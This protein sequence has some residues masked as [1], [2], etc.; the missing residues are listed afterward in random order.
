MHLL[1][2]VHGAEPYKAKLQDPSGQVICGPAFPMFQHQVPRDD[3]P[4]PAAGIFQLKTLHSSKKKIY[5]YPPTRLFLLYCATWSLWG[6]HFLV[7]QQN[8]RG[9]ICWCG[10]A[11]CSAPDLQPE[12]WCLNYEIQIQN[13]W[14][15]LWTR[16]S[17]VTLLNLSSPTVK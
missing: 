4:I 12:K 1:A 9:W 14:S 6:T 5:P 15:L 2:L 10:L 11:P 7:S 13:T 16:A 17:L 8:Y 3:A